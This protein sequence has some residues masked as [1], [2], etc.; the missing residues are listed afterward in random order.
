M[1]GVRNTG[2]KCYQQLVKTNMP[3]GGSPQLFS[4]VLLVFYSLGVEISFSDILRLLQCREVCWDNILTFQSDTLRFYV[5][6]L[7]ISFWPN[8]ILSSSKFKFSVF[9]PGPFYLISSWPFL[10][11]SAWALCSSFL[12]MA[13]CLLWINENTGLEEFWRHVKVFSP[14]RKKGISAIIFSLPYIFEY[15]WFFSWHGENKLLWKEVAV[16]CFFKF[17]E[18]VVWESFWYR[19]GKHRKTSSQVWIYCK[20]QILRSLPP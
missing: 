11:N 7:C 5:E 18:V 10:P 9:L 16:P 2:V 12:F 14:E 8:Q 4:C 20:Q 15:S 19:E 3:G 17:L 1:S 6:V 13:F